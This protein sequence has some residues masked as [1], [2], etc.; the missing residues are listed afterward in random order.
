MPSVNIQHGMFS[1]MDLMTPDRDAA[2]AF[3]GELFGWTYE[4]VPTDLGVPY[5]ICRKNGSDVGG[6]MIAAPDSP[7]PPS[8]NTYVLVDDIEH[9]ATSATEHGGTL[10]HPI[11]D[12]MTS[13]RM[14]VIQDP[15]GGVLCLWQALEQRGAG[16][17]NEHGSLIWNEL[18]THDVDA[19][20]AYYAAVLG[21]TYTAVDMPNGT[22]HLIMV[23][24]RRIGGIMAI[25]P[26]MPPEMP[27]HWGVYIA[28]DDVDPAVEDIKRLG[29]TLHNGPF[30]LDVGRFAVVADPQGAA[31]TAF[32]PN[33][34]DD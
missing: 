8:W 23:G 16:V 7:V 31:F 33:E 29:G 10:H 22:Y 5:T 12:V 20:K 28:V 3:Y 30:D 34:I 19:A 6:I 27:P 18:L 11:T 9:A 25:G 2:K 15:T 13:G 24:E 26:D 21:W 17:F 4:D 32:K 14:C 1:W